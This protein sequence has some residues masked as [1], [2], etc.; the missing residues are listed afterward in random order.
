[1]SII[2]DALKKLEQKRQ[3][4]PVPD[5]MTVHAPEPEEPNNKRPLWPYLVLAALILN[6]G[7][8]AAVFR[9]WESDEQAVVVESISDQQSEPLAVGPEQ[10]DI[11]NGEPVATAPATR[12]ENV[13]TTPKTNDRKP[14]THADMAAEETKTD[15]ATNRPDDL[16]QAN[17]ENQS[18]SM[19]KEYVPEKDGVKDEQSLSDEAAAS[20]DFNVSIEELE[21]LRKKIKEETSL[22]GRDVPIDSGS[23]QGQDAPTVSEPVEDTE[24]ESEETVIELSQLP[25]EIRSEL[26]DIS[27]SG[28]I[29][30]DNPSS[31]LANINGH[32][33]REGENVARGLTVD[34]I[35]LSGVIFRYQDFRFRVRAF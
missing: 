14:V 7:I 34:E 18:A 27:I 15:T 29:F 3:K 32:I 19:K 1:M 25:S 31:R 12:E 11:T 22:E 17:A 33:V 16:P 20:A 26:P 35:T 30:S 13:V 10:E 2:L 4:G 23:L 8:L 24:A 6:A 5:L 9:P 21:A 28:H